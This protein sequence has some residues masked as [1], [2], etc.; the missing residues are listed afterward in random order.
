[1]VTKS[2]HSAPA[3]VAE[4]IVPLAAAAGRKNGNKWKPPTASDSLLIVTGGFN[5]KCEVAKSVRYTI[6]GTT[7]HYVELDKNTQ[8][9][10]KGVGG[11][12]TYKGDLKAVNVISAIR[13]KWSE[14]AVAE[15]KACGDADGDV[16]ADDED[17]PMCALQSICPTSKA[18]PRKQR[19]VPPRATVYDLEMPKRPRCAVREPGAMVT[20]SVYKHGGYLTRASH[21][22]LRSDCIEW[23]LSYGADELHFQGIQGDLPVDAVAAI[24]GENAN[25]AAVAD[26]NLEWDFVQRHWDAAFVSGRYVGTT[27]RFRITEATASRWE[28]ITQLLPHLVAT[29]CPAWTAYS[30]RK[31]VAKEIASAW[32]EAVVT[33]G[34]GLFET[35]WG[36]D[37]AV[38]E[39][40]ASTK[41]RRRRR[42][43]RDTSDSDESTN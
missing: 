33:E 41:S 38:E 8:W 24:A 9:F 5:T 43:K 19:S 27:R 1:M 11:P 25:C 22:F 2:S 37:A 31:A 32:G 30:D 35:V 26:L 4:R 15:Q 36:E 13:D 20:V 6:N 23:L 21:L 12:K 3:A 17:D 10:L 42:Q 34:I 28:Q 16:D 18:K 40:R 7:A 29:H 39:E 14:A